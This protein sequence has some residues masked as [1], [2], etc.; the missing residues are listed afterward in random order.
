MLAWLAPVYSSPMTPK[1]FRAALS[2]LGLS[3][4]EAARRLRVA[5][6]TVQRWVHGDRKIPGPVIS[7]LESWERERR[8]LAALKRER[9]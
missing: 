5:V 9:D 3:Q 1:E 2:T 8:A 7:C 6:S 4:S